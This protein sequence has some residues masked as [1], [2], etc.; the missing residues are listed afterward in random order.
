MAKVLVTE[1][2][3]PFG[4]EL[5]AAAGHQMVFANRNM[6]KTVGIIGLGRIGRLFA[7]MCHQGFGMNV[8]A[9]NPLKNGVAAI[10]YNIGRYLSVRLY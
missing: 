1:S 6:A 7:M 5:I 3:H 4:M 8:L 9:R 2:I 10:P